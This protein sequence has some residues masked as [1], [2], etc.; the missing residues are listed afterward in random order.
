[1][2]KVVWHVTMSLD[3]FIAD[4]NDSVEALLKGFTGP[5]ALADEIIRPTGAFMAGGRVFRADEV[6]PPQSTIRWTNLAFK[7]ATYS[8]SK[9]G[10]NP[11]VSAT[12]EYLSERYFGAPFGVG[13]KRRFRH[14]KSLYRS[15]GSWR[16][17]HQPGA[18]DRAL[19]R[20]RAHGGRGDV[21]LRGQRCRTRRGDRPMIGDDLDVLVGLV[22][23][24]NVGYVPGLPPYAP[25][26]PRPRGGTIPGEHEP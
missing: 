20:S 16:G 17:L 25:P 23:P 3:G 4:P 5:S 26:V 6:L 14:G 22:G 2:S 24:G 15:R 10:G 11:H 9:D 8:G 21:Q 1:M 13:G 7:C 18:V 19:P 12:P